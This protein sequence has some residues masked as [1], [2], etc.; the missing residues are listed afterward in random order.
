MSSDAPPALP[1]AGKAKIF[2]AVGSGVIAA[3][4]S[5][6]IDTC[7]TCMQGD[8]AKERYGT[9]S[10]TAST[11][12]KEGGA[13]ACLG[14]QKMFSCMVQRGVVN[15]PALNNDCPLQRYAYE[16]IRDPPPSVFTGQDELHHAQQQR[17]RCFPGSRDAGR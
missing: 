6:P 17:K 16:G 9:L 14:P 12:Y 10:H 3:T 11:L 7:K 1:H 2:G 8:I 13:G 4:L 5:H 15:C